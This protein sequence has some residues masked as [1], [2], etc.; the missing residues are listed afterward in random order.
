MIRRYIVFI[1]ALFALLGSLTALFGTL[2]QRQYQ[3]RGYVDATQEANLP[4]RVPRLGANVELTQYTLAE[5]EHQL[6]LMEAA[7]IVWLRQYFR[8]DEIEPKPGQ[9]EWEQ[10]DNIVDTVNARPN[11]RIIAVLAF[12]PEWARTEL[13]SDHPT[14]PPDNPQD[15]ARFAEAFAERYG[16]EIHHYEIWDEPNIRDG[17]GG[18]EP[19]AAD[20]V[21]LLNA[22]YQAVHSADQTATVLN[23]GLAPT[24][25]TGS[26]NISDILY[27][28]QLYA[29]GAGKFMDAVAAKPIGFEISPLDRTV[30]NAILNFSRVVAL[31]EEMVRNG[32][33]T[34][35]LW[36]TAWGW[37]SLPDDWTGQPSIWEN[38]TASEQVDFTLAALDRVELEWPWLA[39]MALQHWQ[40]DTHSDD[41]LWGFALVNQENEP[42]AIWQALTAR[43]QSAAAINGLYHPTTPYARYSGVWTFSDFGVDVGWL[44][45]SQLDFDF[46]GRDIA[47]LLREDD[48]VAYLYPTIDNQPANA[49]PH[50][51]DGNA[52][53]VLTSGSLQPERNLVS[54]AHNLQKAPHTM[55]IVVDRGWD[56]WA[57]AGYAVSDGNLA[58]PFDRQITLALLTIIISGLS[59][60]VTGWHIDWQPLTC[61]I[62]GL[63]QRLNDTGQLV[64]SAITSIALMLGMLLTWNQA[65][66]DILRRDSI[67]LALAIL[68]AGIIYINPAF[69]FTILAVVLLFA[70]IYHRLDIG[71]TL[72]IFWTPFFLFPVE[73]YR[74]AFPMVEVIILMTSTAWLLRLLADW[75]HSRQS[76]VSQFPRPTIGQYLKQVKPLDYAIIAWL[77]VGVVSLLWTV[78]RAEAI[79]E[80]RTMMIE[81][82]LFYL[83][84][85][86]IPLDRK[87]ITRLV[88]TLLLAGF[89]VAVIGFATY[90]NPALRITAEGGAQR[91]TSVYG[92]PNNVGLFLGRC[93]PF[94]LAWLI[95]RTDRRR[96]LFAAITLTIMGIA[97]IL[98]QSVGALFVGIPTAL[99]AVIILR[100]RQ[101]AWK[102]LVILTILFAVALA[103]AL[104]FPRFAR[105]LDF[106]DGTN[107][108]R[109]RVWQSTVDMIE[110]HPI[111][112]IGLDQFLYEFRGHYIRPDAEAE[113]NLSHPH[114]VI[115]DFWIRLGIAGVGILIGIQIAFWKQLR[116]IYSHYR[117]HDPLLF[118]LTIGVIGSM[119]NLLAHGLIDNS[120]Y[121]I[122][123]AY[124][125]VFLLVLA[126]RLPNIRAIDGAT[127]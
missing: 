108:F 87:L 27:L 59:F 83:V 30:D 2:Q 61:R 102:P 63:W 113:P 20:Y 44:R 15:F 74:F 125:F 126:V 38:V 94:A 7:N 119:V 55:H 122:D 96:R 16:Q 65:T 78:R 39:G 56:R 12:A 14:A 73:L 86:T 50:D 115:L 114:N 121:I 49:T 109:I 45:D 106:S 117:I 5:L 58:E 68:T 29:H 66:P 116:K 120:V 35:A 110:D 91:L 111:T 36:A 85:R 75:G 28:Q 33:G 101:K 9:Y 92:S 11:L 62:S 89:A 51:A 31:R 69:I 53:I 112:G 103:F 77:A 93:I 22:A 64:I 57:L 42:G 104:Q 54:V 60:V 98:S 95:I 88:D 118:A 4:F 107:F 24:V 40:P 127:G 21:A 3:L 19:R 80:L 100:W 13:A 84:L 6:D 10:W 47:L 70:I 97:V 76:K 81:P 52:Y 99:I 71:L 72:T 90:L 123:L 105:V 25:E 41:P 46:V 17:W 67:Q 43:K 26:L 37:N 48:Y 32:D 124:V 18:M 82:A 79:T 1:A 8:W 23:G 34:K